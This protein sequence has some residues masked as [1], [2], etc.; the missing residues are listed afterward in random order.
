MCDS[1]VKR[2]N[3]SRLFI[4]CLPWVMCSGNVNGLTRQFKLKNEQIEMMMVK[5]IMTVFIPVM[6]SGRQSSNMLKVWSVYPLT[7]MTRI[8]VCWSVCDMLTLLLAFLE[9]LYLLLMFVY[10]AWRLC[11]L[12]LYHRMHNLFI[13]IFDSDLQWKLTDQVSQKQKKKNL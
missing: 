6:Y 12:L 13:R 11:G 5:Q 3:E 10:F 9:Y 8:F 7:K 1:Y 2:S 4:Y